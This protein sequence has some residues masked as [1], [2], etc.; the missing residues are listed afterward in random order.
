MYL[1]EQS[2]SLFPTLIYICFKMPSMSLSITP[3]FYNNKGIQS[4][5][6]FN[7]Y[8]WFADPG[9]YFSLIKNKAWGILIIEVFT[10]AFNTSKP[11]LI[12]D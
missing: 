11:I 3:P 9:F 7:T 2:Y 12:V 4:K 1:Y 6:V 5:S 8:L 10:F